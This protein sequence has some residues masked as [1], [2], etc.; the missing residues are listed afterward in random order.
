MRLPALLLALLATSSCGLPR[1]PEGTLER[2]RGGVLRV[3]AVADPPWVG[4]DTDHLRGVEVALARALAADLGA[5]LRWNHGGET[6]LMAALQ[7]F[8]LDLVIGGITEDSPYADEV[9]FTR[10]YYQGHVLAG[11]PGEN[12]WLMTLEAFLRAHELEVDELLV[13]EQAAQEAAQ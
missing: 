7:N 13:R 6:R 1:D 8:E 10:P 12:A 9:G 5:E 3:G 11:P 4:R 2:V